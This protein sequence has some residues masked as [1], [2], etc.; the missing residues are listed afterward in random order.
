MKKFLVILA[1]IFLTL[2]AGNAFAN[3]VWY[4]PFDMG[5][6][7]SLSAGRTYLSPSDFKK[8]WDLSSTYD[9]FT[10]AAE[11]KF[12]RVAALEAA[13]GSLHYHD[14]V[15]GV[16][17]SDDSVNADIQGYYLAVTPKFYLRTTETSAFYI[18]GGP[19]Y[20]NV[21]IDLDYSTFSDSG[22]FD[23]TFQVLGAQAFAGAEII[24]FRKQ[25]LTGDFDA[26]VSLFIEY[27]YSWVNIAEADD[28]FIDDVNA[29]AGTSDNSHDLALGGNAGYF[30]LRWRF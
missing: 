2:S 15:H 24:F 8:F 29:M 7:V 23:E 14:R 4:G 16:F 22:G 3:D 18:G 9:G 13:I 10:F 26:P 5:Y 1:L 25:S 28:E 17:S 12:N 30:G 11:K 6:S 19:A 20:Y 27:R 21:E